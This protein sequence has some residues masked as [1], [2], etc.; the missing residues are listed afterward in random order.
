MY[1]DTYALKDPGVTVSAFMPAFREFRYELLEHFNVLWSTLRGMGQPILGNAVQ[2]APLFPLNLVLLALPDFLYWSVMPISRIILIA[3]SCYLIARK[4]FGLSTFASAFFGLLIAFNINVTRWMNHPWTNGLLAGLWYFYFICRVSLERKANSQLFIS[5]GL[6]VSVFA[7]VTAGFPE[8]TALS[9]LIVVFL[10]AGFFISYWSDIQARLVNVVILLLTCHVI[11]FCLSAI[12]IFPLFEYIEYSRLLEL[13]SKFSSGYFTS[14]QA[15]PYWSSQLSTFWPSAGQKKYLIFSV[16]LFGLFFAIH[17]LIAFIRGLISKEK[18]HIRLAISIA[19]L[20]SMI[21]FVTKNFGLSKIV[22]QIFASIP[23]LAHSHFPLYFSPLFYLGTAYFSSLGFHEVFKRHDPSP[24]K[25]LI[26]SLFAFLITALL[27]S[28]TAWYFHQIK[29]I[30]FWVLMLI[31][32]QGILSIQ[33]FVVVISSLIMYQLVK[34]RKKPWP[35]ITKHIVPSIILAALILELNQSLPKSFY[36]RDPQRINPQLR[37]SQTLNQAL[38]NSPLPLHEL[39]GRDANGEFAGLGLAT[40]DNGAS[41]ILP[42][43]YRALRL[44]L[45]NTSYG[46]YLPLSGPIS[47]WSYGAMSANIKSVHATAVSQPDWQEHKLES[48]INTQVLNW[49]SNKIP[50][51]NPFFMQ[52]VV[53][54]FFESPANTEVWLHFI[55]KE[56]S[57]WIKT[58]IGSLQNLGI[59][60]KR[61]KYITKWRI[62]VLADW[63]SEDRYDIVVRQ[64]NAINREYH[65]IENL[66]LTF[67]RQHPASIAGKKKILLASRED[68]TRSF[69]F[70]TTALPRAYIAKGCQPS[71]SKKHEKSFYRTSN[72]VM[73]GQVV[74]PYDAPSQIVPCETYKSTFARLP[75]T[76]DDRTK[77]HFDTVQG[78]AL[79]ILNDSYYPGW[80]AFDSASGAKSEMTIERANTNARSVYLPES[81]TYKLSMEFQPA[82]LTWVYILTGLGILMTLGL[83]WLILRRGI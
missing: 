53:E 58:N 39:R 82:W 27:C 46:G 63:I 4:I 10:Y 3:L 59:T 43:E 75:I 40:V 23:V 47:D 37:H 61:Y 67:D 50:L 19:F 78:P 5:I 6:I 28:Y 66:T 34:L 7:M 8:A 31:T 68:K 35:K 17:G 51:S 49:N 30:N 11:G 24:T 38:K 72:D 44:S 54:G 21:F 16:G 1:G 15:L 57:F 13:R 56:E 33:V 76:R 70:D 80:K 41:A 74:F 69:L 42:V 77:L 64:V 48:S 14:E 83:W 60:N 81:R 65:D 22:D 2:S 36:H 32:E 45:F 79:V 20:V 12:Q 73:K 71:N 29:L 52:G 62:R 9:A 26:I 55:G 25:T 18:T